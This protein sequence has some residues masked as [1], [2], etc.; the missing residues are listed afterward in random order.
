MESSRHLLAQ[1]QK[2]RRDPLRNS[3]EILTVETLQAD[4]F[5]GPRRTRARH[6]AQSVSDT[7]NIPASDET[8]L[9]RFA[10][11]KLDYLNNAPINTVDFF[12]EI[13]GG[14]NQFPFL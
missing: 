5:L 8:A 10:G 7:E 3:D 14:I 2:K 9:I 13:A 6:F 4:D 11:N 12:G 1:E